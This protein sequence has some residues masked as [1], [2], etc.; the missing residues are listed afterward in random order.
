[1][2]LFCPY[3]LLHRKIYAK[4]ILEYFLV[5]MSSWPAY[6][7]VY[8]MS[9]WGQQRTREGVGSPRAGVTGSCELLDRYW[10]LN[11]HCWR[12]TRAV[13]HWVTS[14]LLYSFLALFPLGFVGVQNDFPE[15]IFSGTMFNDHVIYNSPCAHLDS[16]HFLQEMAAESP[17]AL[18]KSQEA[19][20]KKKTT[21]SLIITFPE[22]NLGSF[23][24]PHEV[25]ETEPP[26]RS[27]TY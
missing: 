27:E 6:M 5:C 26:R 25:I 23:L 8:H 14:P 3:L 16:W 7:S 2:F 1:M 4:Y 22:K 13:K 24:G 10:K 9:T 12:A 17:S 11:P 18:C 20:F 19:S 15:S 21:Q